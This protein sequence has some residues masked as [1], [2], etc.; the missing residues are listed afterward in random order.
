MAMHICWPV[1][2]ASLFHFVGGDTGFMAFCRTC[3]H[4]LSLQGDKGLSQA[5]ALGY[6]LSQPACLWGPGAV[7]VHCRTKR[8]R[9]PLCGCWRPTVQPFLFQD[10]HHDAAHE[11]IETIR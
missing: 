9:L 11:I 6:E 7:G 1:A 5:P 4:M 3:L 10:K 2:V 8:I